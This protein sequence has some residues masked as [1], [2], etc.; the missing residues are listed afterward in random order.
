MLK[1]FQKIIFIGSPDQDI[2]F[3]Y[4][5]FFLKT[6]NILNTNCKIPV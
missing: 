1:V 2:V 6:I 4:S 3:G 5:N